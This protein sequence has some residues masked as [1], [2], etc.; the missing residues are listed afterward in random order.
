MQ[1]LVQVQHKIPLK[2]QCDTCFATC[3]GSWI[4]GRGY[5]C[6]CEIQSPG[7]VRLWNSES[8]AL[9]SEI[10]LTIGIQNRRSTDEDWNPVTG[11]RNPRRGI[12]NPRLSG[13]RR[14]YKPRGLYSRVL[15][16][17]V[18][19]CFKTSYISFLIK[20][21][22]LHL[23]VQNVIIN[24]IEVNTFFWRGEVG[25][26]QSDVFFGM[27]VDRLITGGAYKRQ[28]TVKFL[29]IFFLTRTHRDNFSTYL[30]DMDRVAF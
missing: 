26:L 21:P 7:K 14:G 4:P 16:T 20:K 15:L 10:P 18:E 23:L 24:Q 1:C 25:G 30:P 12:Q 8:W 3:K 13:F 22:F 17:G 11:I 27:P 9:E 6:A 28:F 5:I 29:G 2:R 19:K